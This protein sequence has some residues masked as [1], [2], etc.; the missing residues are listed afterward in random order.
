MTAAVTRHMGKAEQ[1]DD[2]TMLCVKY[3][4]RESCPTETE[5]ASAGAAE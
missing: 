3:L 5:D 1:F 4:G 2:A